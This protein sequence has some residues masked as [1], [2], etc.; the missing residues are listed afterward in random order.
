MP[1]LE[2]IKN[3][4][5][6]GNLFVNKRSDN[7]KEHLYRYCVRSLD[8]L[9][10]KVIPFFKKNSLKTYKRNDFEIFSRIVEMMSERIHLKE[11]GRNKIAK[12]VEG[13]N[14]KKQSRFLKSSDT[15]RRA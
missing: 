15:I 6:C 5:D 4:F 12:L 7:H 14:R 9:K 3:Y 13:M 11:S 1:A 8:D 2:I 10:T